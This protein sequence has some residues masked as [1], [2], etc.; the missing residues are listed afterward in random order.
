MSAR[1]KLNAGY[2]TGS[3]LV[4]AVAGGVTQSWL[5]FGLALAVLVGLNLYRNEIRPPGGNHHGRSRW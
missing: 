4:A 5:V 3:L 2:F 1:R